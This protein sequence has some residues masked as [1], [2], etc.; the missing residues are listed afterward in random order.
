MNILIELALK[1]DAEN[2]IKLYRDA[3]SE[4]EKMGFPASATKATVEEV[5]KWI[6]ETILL[7]ASDTITSEL[8]GTIRFK[9]NPTWGCYVLS[10]LAVKSSYK[11]KGL[12]KKLIKFGED[13]VEKMNEKTVRLTVAIPHPFLVNMYIKLGYK[14][15]GERILENL[16][17]DEFIM[18]KVLSETKE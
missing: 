9:Y 17:Y 16:P 5:E 7:I 1:Q 15:K 2:L 18:E 6:E 12:G 8:I 11:G 10:R 4:N 3:Y 14:I 13:Y